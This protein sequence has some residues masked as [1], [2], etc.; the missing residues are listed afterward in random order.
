MA[1][2]KYSKTDHRY[3]I[4]KLFKP[5]RVTG[6]ERYSSPFW[7]VRLQH[8]TERTTFP[9]E[10]ANKPAAAT[11][12]R[13][14]YLFMLAHGWQKTLEEFKGYEPAPEKNLNATLGDFLAELETVADLKPKTFE[15]YS[16]SLRTIVSQIFGID[17]GRARYDYIGGGRQQW[18]ERIHAVKLADITPAKV[19]A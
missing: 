5:V 7:C 11:R 13:D 6:G 2:Q 15:G 9:L 12:A 18:I 10:T 19:Q 3:W 16:I 17:G 4:P 1:K 14:I 8:E